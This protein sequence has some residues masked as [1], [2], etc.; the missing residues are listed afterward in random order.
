MN[1]EGA[2][3]AAKIGRTQQFSFSNGVTGRVQLVTGLHLKPTLFVL[4][5]T[6]SVYLRQG[7]STVEATTSDT[8][9]QAGTYTHVLVES[10]ADAYLACY[11]AGADGVLH[12]TNAS[13]L[14][15]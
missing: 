3:S 12:Y 10:L 8:L 1:L 6:E 13:R 11:G 2:L 15:E 4:R 5:T 14:R 7:G 9:L